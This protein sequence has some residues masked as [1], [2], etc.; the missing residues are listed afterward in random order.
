MKPWER[1][2]A[3]A[4]SICTILGLSVWGVISHFSDH[5][6]SNP[7]TNSN[8]TS[9]S[10]SSTIPAIASADSFS[11]SSTISVPTSSVISRVLVSAS[12]SS[13]LSH[14][15]PSSKIVSSSKISNV[16]SKPISSTNIPADK[17]VFNGHSYKVYDISKN[18]YDAESYCESLDGHLVTIT[19]PGEQLFIQ[20]IIK[21][22]KKNQYWLG[23]SSANPN[24]NWEWVTR[25]AWTYND[26]WDAREP[27]D[28][29]DV[30]HYLE[31]YRLPNPRVSRSLPGKWNDITVNN[32]IKGE[33]NFFLAPFV[34]FICEWDYK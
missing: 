33:E 29:L 11:I 4:A 20:N 2:L 32:V 9:S 24:G 19:S 30:E 27:D 12:T 5:S 14:A 23:A 7:P 18:W 15:S 8:N 1:G 21:K 34:G 16:S 13:V 25:E 28:N 17:T 31:I 22:G 10:I 3:I 26:G 6:S